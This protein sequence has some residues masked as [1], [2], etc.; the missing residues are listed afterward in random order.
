VEA[1]NASLTIALRA[2]VN[3]TYLLISLFWS[4]NYVWEHHFIHIISGLEL[5]FVFV[6][7]TLSVRTNVL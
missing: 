2:L 6:L 1:L 7:I 3:M 5:L 4:F